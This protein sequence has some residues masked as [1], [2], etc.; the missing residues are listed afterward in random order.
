[1]TKCINMAR[2]SGKTTLLIHSSFVTGAPIV[3]YDSARKSSVI[4]QA[5]EQDLDITVYTLR[6]WLENRSLSRCVTGLLIDEADLII[7]NALECYLGTK[8]LAYTVSQ[9]IIDRNKK[10]E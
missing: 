4:A 8:V 9:P 2:R 3:V 1:M 7:E 5:K 10:E 6:E